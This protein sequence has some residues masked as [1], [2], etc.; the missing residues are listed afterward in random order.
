MEV[1]A[2]YLIGLLGRTL[3]VLPVVGIL[4]SCE[5]VRDD[6]AECPEP[7]QP[8]QEL[9]FVYDYNME[10]AN[11][12]HN[13]VHCLSAYFFNDNGHLIAVKTVTDRDTL[14]DE[15]YRM[16]PGLP[17]GKYR[18]VA[19]GGMD[20]DEAS[21]YHVRKMNI[22]THYSDIH[23]RLDSYVNEDD[24]PDDYRRLHNHY[25][26]AADFT[27]S[28][29]EDT[30]AT[31]SMMRNTNSIQVA[32]QNEQGEYIDHNDFVFE[33]TDDNNDFDHENNLLTTGEITYKPWNTANRSTG[34]G[35]RADDVEEKE[36][37]AALAQ[38]TTSRLVKPTA[39]NNKRTTTTLHVRR[40][41]DGETVF[42]IPLINY[43]L[44]F[45]HDNS[46]AG[47]DYMSDQEY[48]DRENTWNFVFFLKDGMWVSSHIIINDWEVRMNNTDF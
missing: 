17:A 11:A 31:I 43:M 41:K 35:S 33:I 18:V 5:L 36:W 27:V 2:K 26:G 7:V 14:S 42:R 38:F 48:L 37:Y 20:C 4:F 6:L 22:G 9:R 15:T 30:R 45:K 40:T 19:Y 1:I 16:N 47:L 29:T 34:K 3:V 24:A 10:Y 46:G 28:D 44:M 8:V 12:F 21:F 39:A 32:L 13:Q 25:Y 23:V